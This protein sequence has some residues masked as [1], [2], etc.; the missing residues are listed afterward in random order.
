[1]NGLLICAL[2]VLLGIIVT[3]PLVFLLELIGWSWTGVPYVPASKAVLGKLSEV[4]ELKDSS[5]LYDLGSGDGRILYTLASKSTAHFV[6]VEKAPF[7]YLASLI[8]GFIARKKNVRIEYGDIFKTK[9]E[10][11]THVYVYLLSDVMDK[12]LPKFEKELKKGTRL[13]SCD[14]Q[15]KNRA[16]TSLLVIGKG[17]SAH[18]LYVY[19]F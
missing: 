3:V 11:A 1:M 10:N 13:V 9:L 17:Y 16:P 6:G 8:R 5:I 7:P 12:L 14:F 2:L 4:L 19:D 18:T 15:F